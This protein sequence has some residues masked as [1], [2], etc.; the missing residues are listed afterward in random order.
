[1]PEWF[2]ICLSALQTT[3]RGNRRCT[4]FCFQSRYTRTWNKAENIPQPPP[5]F[6]MVPKYILTLFLAAASILKRYS[7]QATVC[8]SGLTVISPLFRVFA[9]DVTQNFRMW[10]E[11]LY[12]WTA[13][14]RHANALL[15]F[16]SEEAI[17]DESRE[18]WEL[19]CPAARSKGKTYIPTSSAC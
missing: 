12:T 5:V 2:L 4:M 19:L 3:P 8:A 17:L 14:N 16:D 18:I 6:C 7:R 10:R 9:C 15:D 1:M 11:I 13:E